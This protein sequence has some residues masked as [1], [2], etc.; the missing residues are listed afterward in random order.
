MVE[1][2]I[3]PLKIK[4]NVS[5]M[6]ILCSVNVTRTARALAARSGFKICIFS[7]LS[8]ISC[9]GFSDSYQTVT[10]SFAPSKIPIGQVSYLTTTYEA[11]GNAK[12]TGLGLR[13]HFDSSEL[14]MGDYTDRLRESAQ[15]FEIKDDIND[16][17]SDSDTDKY[18]LTSWADTSGDGWPDGS[19]QPVTLYRV[20]FTSLSGFDGSKINLTASST[21]PGYGVRHNPSMDVLDIDG[22][23][24]YEPLMDGLLA[25]RYLFGLEGDTLIANVVSPSATRTS[26]SDIE[27]YLQSITGN[28]DIDGDGQID[29]LTDGLVALRYL[30]GLEG[31][32]LIGGVLAGG[33][34]RTSADAIQGYLDT[35][36]SMNEL[37]ILTESSLPTQAVTASGLSSIAVGQAT[38]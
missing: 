20:P 9:L 19:T 18:F 38:T 15:P 34:T 12:L 24:Y 6:P 14:Q 22:D 25:L 35:L 23:G 5:L 21:A 28:I 30:F 36:T 1:K 10:T 37:K 29:A 2:G 26:S 11:S 17:D 33:A 8:F 7:V 4:L 13:L 3:G 16:F 27:A 31:D 32:T